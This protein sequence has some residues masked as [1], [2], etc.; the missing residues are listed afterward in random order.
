MNHYF[1][2]IPKQIVVDPL[3][4]PCDP[5]DDPE[6][7][8]PLDMEEV[9]LLLQRL[10]PWLQFACVFTAVEMVL[11]IWHYNRFVWEVSQAPAYEKSGPSWAMQYIQDWFDGIPSREHHRE[12]TL[13]DIY[14]LA[15]RI[16][17]VVSTVG[18]EAGEHAD[19]YAGPDEYF[20]FLGAQAAAMAVSDLARTPELQKGQSEPTF[21]HHRLIQAMRRTLTA[22]MLNIGEE[23]LLL[24]DEAIA[25][26]EEPFLLYD[27][28]IALLN[29]AFLDEWWKQCRCRLAFILP[30]LT[31]TP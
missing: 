2:L 31:P 7:P 27:E 26:G 25:L 15:N 6:W 23:S 13:N 19:P 3:E 30:K 11:P 18:R 10:S 16:D 20:S 17:H 12:I 29:S 22:N 5:P 8:S 9:E 24:Y 1:Q 21:S 28:A 4:I 14:S